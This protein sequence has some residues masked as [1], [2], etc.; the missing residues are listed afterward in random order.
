MHIKA[1][2][3][4]FNLSIKVKCKYFVLWIYILLNNTINVFHDL[5]DFYLWTYIYIIL[6]MYGSFNMCQC[7]EYVQSNLLLILFLSI[8]VAKCLITILFNPMSF[9]HNSRYYVCIFCLLWHAAFS[10]LLKSLKYSF[11]REG[12]E[13]HLWNKEIKNRRIFHGGFF[14]V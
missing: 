11:L 7:A 6:C 9:I 3:H 13:I 2:V 8:I 10:R 12:K 14:H 5:I 1:D 4:W